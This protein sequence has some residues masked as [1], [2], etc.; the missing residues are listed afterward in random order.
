[1]KPQRERSDGVRPGRLGSTFSSFMGKKDCFRFLMNV[2]WC[3]KIRDT[4][5][6]NAK[7]VWCF[8]IFL[9]SRSPL[10]S[11]GVDFPSVSYTSAL[12]HGQ[13]CDSSWTADGMRALAAVHALAHP[14]YKR[15]IAFDPHCVLW[16]FGAAVWRIPCLVLLS[17]AYKVSYKTFHVLEL[18]FDAPSPLLAIG[19]D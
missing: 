8:Q 15:N 6:Q 13:R 14:S 12:W 17:E 10:Y 11:V 18:W 5:V 2:G 9:I 4:H 3:F 16:I 7:P 1:M 19:I